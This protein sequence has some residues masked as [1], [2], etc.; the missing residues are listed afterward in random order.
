M[1]TTTDYSKVQTAAKEVLAAL[2]VRKSGDNRDEYFL[3]DGSP[4]WMSDIML[5]GIEDTSL[6]IAYEF[7][8]EALEA[9]ARA[10]ADE[11]EIRE[12]I[13]QIEAD[14]YTREV[15][16]WLAENLNHVSWMDEVMNNG[17]WEDGSALD[18]LQSAQAMHKHAV[19][20][21]VLNALEARAGDMPDED[22]SESEWLAGL[23]DL[24]LSDSYA[25]TGCRQA[26]GEIIYLRDTDFDYT[27]QDT[28]TYPW[29]PTLPGT[30]H[31]MDVRA[32]LDD[33]SSSLAL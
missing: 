28:N 24:G 21:A 1:R 10:D 3:A 14:I 13:D 16:N 15:L 20:W 22:D 17:L 4:D 6:Y 26:D 12:E 32:L 31:L 9:I 7:G 29:E 5:A 27:G 2:H 8:H 30:V 18:L 23:D 11:S 25:F 33:M 19:A